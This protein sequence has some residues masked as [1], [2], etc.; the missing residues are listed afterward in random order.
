VSTP[1]PK[2]P[3]QLPCTIICNDGAR[4]MIRD[5]N[6]FGL[7]PKDTAFEYLGWNDDLYVH[8]YKELPYAGK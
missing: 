2:N 4:H 6:D 1:L 5:V 7:I 3:F 8:V